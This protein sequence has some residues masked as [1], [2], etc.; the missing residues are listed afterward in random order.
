MIVMRL[1]FIL[2]AL[3]SLPGLAQQIAVPELRQQ[4][5][6]ITGTLS[7]SEQQSLT[8]QLQDI[9]QKTRA[10][11]AVLIVPSTEDD[12][13]E[14]YATRVFDSWKLGDAQRNDGILLLVAWEDHTVRIEVGYGLEGVVTDLQAAK[15]ISD[16]LIP[17]FKNNDLM[18]GLTLASE[19]IGALLSNGELPEGRGNH[20]SIK[21]PIPLSVAVIILLAVLSY[22]IIFTEPS[23]LPWIAL[24]GAIYGMVFLYVAEPGPWTFL[25]V[26]CGMLT[27]FAIVP[28]LIFWLLVN[29]KLR[30]KYKKLGKERASRKGSSSSS[31]GGGSSGGGFSG[32]GGSSGGGGASG[33]W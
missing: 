22:F 18:G 19:N 13:I 27:P 8:Q 21:T 10:Q 16:I 7:T 9:T 2:L 23:N 25:I 15:I 28:L 33:R 32:G 4:V 6:D 26:A 29:K 30:A 20:Y 11:V 12:T 31:S 3:W 1:I 14:Q 17:A 24:T 5:T